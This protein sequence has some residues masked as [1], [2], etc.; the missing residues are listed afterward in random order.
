MEVT[1]NAL[2]DLPSSSPSSDNSSDS[3]EETS[4][5][6]GQ[7]EYQSLSGLSSDEESEFLTLPY[8]DTIEPVPTEEEA[9]EYLEQLAIEEEDEQTLLSRFS[10]EEDV[11]VWYVDNLNAFLPRKTI[12]FNSEIIVRKINQR[13][14]CSLEKYALAPIA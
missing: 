14:S 8:D 2:D 13:R 4:S 10:G 9:A 7:S 5:E 6:S 1:S 11:S 12:F 3:Y